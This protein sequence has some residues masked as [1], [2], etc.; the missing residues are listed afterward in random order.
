MKQRD[1]FL[2]SEGDAWFSRNQQSVTARKLPDD[3][4]LLR[5]LLDFLPLTAREGL[6]VLEVGCGDGTRLAWIKNHL[7]AECHGIEPSARAVA[8]ACQKGINAQQST[9][10]A[11]LFDSQIF[12]I[13]IFG[14]CLY[15]CDREDLFRIA[16]EADRV[17]RSPGWLMI[18]D[19]Y[20]P[21]P[22]SR[23]YHHRPGVRSYKMDYR[24]LFTWHPDYE[25]MTHK[26]RHHESAGYTDAP[27]EWVTVSVLRKCRREPGA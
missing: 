2:Q 3:D 21:T 27:E 18:L 22:R 5:E 15:L 8:A 7:H 19:F 16:S 25:C 1:I 11:L 12:D 26:V 24:T 10:D 6:K 23:D 14:F 9:A 13:V 17:L 4:L 20:S